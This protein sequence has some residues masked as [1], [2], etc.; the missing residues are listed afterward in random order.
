MPNEP[1]RRYEFDIYRTATEQRIARVELDLRE[2]K[3]DYE[4]DADAEE[5]ADLDRSRWTWQQIVAVVS[6]AGVL[7]GLW[8]QALTARH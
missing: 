5:K 3:Q 2:F 6:V 4:D 8:L 7:V 1:I